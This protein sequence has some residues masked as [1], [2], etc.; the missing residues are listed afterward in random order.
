MRLLLSAPRSATPEHSA[1]RAFLAAAG[2]GGAPL[3]REVLERLPA[4]WPTSW[5]PVPRRADVTPGACGDAARARG[6]L[7]GS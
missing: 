5:A 6:W 3:E 4:A 1:L 2:L 7:L